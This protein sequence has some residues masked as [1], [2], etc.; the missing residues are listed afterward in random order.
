MWIRRLIYSLMIR[1]IW[2][3][4]FNRS[5]CRKVFLAGVL[6]DRQYILHSDNYHDAFRILKKLRK[7][8]VRLVS[9]IFIVYT[10]HWNKVKD[11][12]KNDSERRIIIMIA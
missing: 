6:M 4:R 2:G 8:N 9:A 1:V 5:F 7:R 3:E 10:D 12:M 11:L